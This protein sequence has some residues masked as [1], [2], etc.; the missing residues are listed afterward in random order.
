MKKSIGSG[1][2]SPETVNFANHALLGP[3][4]L[5]A[6]T[7]PRLLFY[8]REWRGF[9]IVI[10]NP[11]HEALSA[12]IPI[13]SA[14]FDSDDTNRKIRALGRKLIAA[15]TPNNITRIKT[16]TKGSVQDSLNFH[17]CAAETIA[18]IDKLYLEALGLSPKPLMEQLR[19]LRGP[20]TWRL[21]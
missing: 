5:A 21:G 6:Q 20:S 2:S 3:D 16:G 14:W 15:I 8:S 12:T 13:P 9:D 18:K 4:A 11:H 17:E 1:M 19:T 10:G 7:D